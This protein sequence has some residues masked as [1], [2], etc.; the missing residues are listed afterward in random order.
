MAEE[1]K[2]EEELYRALQAVCRLP[3]PSIR[4]RIL[5]ESMLAIAKIIG[6]EVVWNKGM[7]GG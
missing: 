5:L 6:V 3:R 1:D 4:Q 7:D 2:V